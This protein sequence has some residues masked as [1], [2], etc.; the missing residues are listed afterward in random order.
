MTRDE[1]DLIEQATT[2]WRP[3]APDGRIRA[4]PAWH[5]LD[6]EG[7]QEAY[8]A[9]VTAR[10]IEAALDP[11]GLSSTGHAVLDRIRSLTR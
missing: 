7:R 1:K 2:A 10:A 3:R 6:A 8:A 4:H 9:T 11:S 5:D